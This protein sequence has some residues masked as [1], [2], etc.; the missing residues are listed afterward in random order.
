MKRI[1]VFS[2]KGGSGKSTLAT[3]GAVIAAETSRVFVGDADEQESVLSWSLVRPFATPTVRAVSEWSAAK[4]LNEEAARGA[5]FAFVDFPPRVTPGV[6]KLVGL[7]DFVVIPC[8]PTA[9][10]LRTVKRT[11][12][13][14]RAHRKPYAFV[15]NRTRRQSVGKTDAAREVL[16]SYGGL[17]CPHA[18]ANLDAYADAF[19]DGRA[20]TEYAPGSVAADD[21]RAAWAW[22][23][24]QIKGAA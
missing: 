19:I 8:Q 15:L 21:I 9:F 6:A 4:I 22:L 12:A 13:T 10:D 24:Q 3:H 18:I 17:V 7:V 16:K 1:G 23:F 14:V 2:Q 5:E 20:V 11:L